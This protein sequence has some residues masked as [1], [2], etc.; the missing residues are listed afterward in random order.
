M[1]VRELSRCRSVV[2]IMLVVVI[3]MTTSGCKHDVASAFSKEVQTDTLHLKEVASQLD[4]IPGFVSGV[5]AVGESVILSLKRAGYAFAVFPASFNSG[6]MLIGHHGRGPGEVLDVCSNTITEEGNGFSFIDA[7]GKRHVRF[8]NGS[9]SI[10]APDN[11][12]RNDS[13]KNSFIELSDSFI[14][15]N[16]DNE[17]E[18]YVV[19]DKTLSKKT[20]TGRF[21]DWTHEYDVLPQFVYMKFL[22]KHP[23]K[24]RFA[25][26]YGRYPV[27]RVCNSQGKTLHEVLT[28]E[29]SF[30]GGM[31]EVYYSCAP[32]VNEKYILAL[33]QRGEPASGYPELHLFDWGGS[34]LKRFVIDRPADYFSVFFDQGRV[35][36]YSSAS[37]SLYSADISL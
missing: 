32:A 37:G 23:H 18:E 13:A 22:A 12:F 19:Y 4:S 16:T 5:S 31:S 10:S 25:A 3:V 35:I 2:Y 27:L 20:Y 28:Y 33:S 21:P 8:E 1:L 29:D 11:D 15:I 7:F 9:Y 34:L 30:H 26:V 17:T 14:D 24:D 36:A 6:P